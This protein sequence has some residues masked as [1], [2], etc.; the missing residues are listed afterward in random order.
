MFVRRNVNQSSQLVDTKIYPSAPYGGICLAGL[1]CFWSIPS[2][3]TGRWPHRSNLPCLRRACA[4]TNTNTNTRRVLMLMQFDSISNP[5]RSEQD[6]RGMQ[7]LAQIQN[8]WRKIPN[9]CKARYLDYQSYVLKYWILTQS[10]DE[11]NFDVIKKITRRR[12]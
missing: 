11:H 10:R 5:H 1:R 7:N 8:F 12:K 9:F 3:S 4:L 6:C 2:W